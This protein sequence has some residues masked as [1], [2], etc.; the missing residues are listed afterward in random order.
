MFADHQGNQ[1]T[2]KVSTVYDDDNWE[3]D[4]DLTQDIV[5]PRVSSHNRPATLLRS[6]TEF[7]N[8]LQL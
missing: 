6:L 2:H 3:R 7:N 8:N 4:K 5:I 1:F